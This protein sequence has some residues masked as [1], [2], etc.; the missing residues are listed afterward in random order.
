MAPMNGFGLSKIR[1]VSVPPPFRPSRNPPSSASHRSH[2]NASVAAGQVG[3]GAER[4]P[5]AGDDH[6]PDVVV[7]I[8][9]V[10]RGD[11]RLD[12]VDRHRVHR[13]GAGST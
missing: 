11:E 3:A 7:G 13:V 8:E 4:A 2:A 9:R 1:R 6:A 12:H 5:G 10:D